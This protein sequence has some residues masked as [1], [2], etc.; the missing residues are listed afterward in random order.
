MPRAPRPPKGTRHK[1]G[2]RRIRV[3]GKDL[4]LGLF[5]DP[6]S[7]EAERRIVRDW[8]LRRVGGQAT[9]V[10]HLIERFVLEHGLVAGAPVGKHQAKQRKVT[11]HVLGFERL[12]TWRVV[13]LIPADFESFL[14]YL[15]G[16]ETVKTDE[17][18]RVVSRKALYT[19]RSC[20]ELGQIFRGIVKWGERKGHV[21][22]GT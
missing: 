20:N 17:A 8:H 16:L 3:D 11:Q 21:P 22:V 12:A 14:D 18:G 4:Y 1:S 15:A 7:L 19:R 2:Q 9:Q 10:Y 13:E 5:D 6:A